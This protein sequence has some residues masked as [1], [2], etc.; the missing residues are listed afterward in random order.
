MTRKEYLLRKKAED[1]RL[2]LSRQQTGQLLGIG[3]TSIDRLVKTKAI[4][5]YLDS[6]GRR[7]IHTNSAYDFEA[8]RDGGQ[9]Y[10]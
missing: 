5:S 6:S 3:R 2:T 1:P 4:D 10:E 8:R 7:R 9:S